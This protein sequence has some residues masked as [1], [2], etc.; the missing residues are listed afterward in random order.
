MPPRWNT[1]AAVQVVQLDYE[2][3]PRER[4]VRLAGP[5]AV[6]GELVRVGMSGVEIEGAHRWHFS[7]VLRVKVKATPWKVRPARRIKSA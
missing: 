3:T 5:A 2:K 4:P 7:N 6:V 1:W